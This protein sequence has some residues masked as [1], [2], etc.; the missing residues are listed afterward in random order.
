MSGK[1]VIYVEWIVSTTK[2]ERCGLSLDMVASQQSRQKSSKHDITNSHFNCLQ[3]YHAEWMESPWQHTGADP[4]DWSIQQ[5]VQL[6]EYVRKHKKINA[7][8]AWVPVNFKFNFWLAMQL[9]TSDSDQEVLGIFTV[10][11]AT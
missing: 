9:A 6:V 11:L 1:K 8:G 7:L 5:Q 10:W 2:S 4:H 3:R